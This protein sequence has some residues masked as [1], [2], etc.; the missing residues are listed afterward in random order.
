MARWIDLDSLDA[1]TALWIMPEDLIKFD[2]RNPP[3]PNSFWPWAYWFETTHPDFTRPNMIAKRRWFERALG[4]DVVVRY[5]GEEFAVIADAVSAEAAQSLAEKLR[6]SIEA[7]A[8]PHPAAESFEH[9]TISAGV[10]AV[11][12]DSTMNMAEFLEK[13]EQSLHL[14]KKEGRNRV[15][16]WTGKAE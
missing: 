9:V 8:I 14:A 13:M 1:D 7:L 11:H 15:A 12:P 10:V 16:H 4:G 2:Q 5:G 3:W 6:A